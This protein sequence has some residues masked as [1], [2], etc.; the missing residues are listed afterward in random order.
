VREAEERSHASRFVGREPELHQ[1]SHAWACGEARASHRQ[2]AGGARALRPQ[3]DCPPRGA[4][5]RAAGDAPARL[6]ARAGGGEDLLR[7]LAVAPA[8]R[9]GPLRRLE[10]L[11]AL[12][13]VLDLVSQLRRDVVDVADAVERGV[14]DR[15]AEKLLVRPL[16]VRHVEDAD[17]AYADAAAGE[18]RVGDEHERVERVAVLRE[19]PL[20]V[21]VVGGIGHRREQSPVEDDAAQLLV[22]LVLV[23][24]AP[25]DLDE[26]DSLVGAA[27]RDR[28]AAGTSA[29][30]RSS[31]RSSADSIP[32]ERRTRF[33][34]AAKG[35]SAVE[36]CVIRAG[37]SIRLST[38]PS[39]SA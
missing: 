22:P 30:S 10:I 39:D 4:L 3:G 14:A 1:L 26:D 15:L 25:R 16:L 38:P 18:G 17:R 6:G 35:A 11:V 36:A 23:P 34:G 32:T 13:E 5:A 7:L 2:L 19:R 9:L 12:E 31:T 21:A 24:R 29:R 37:T 20:D 28:A 27:H 33:G 8:A